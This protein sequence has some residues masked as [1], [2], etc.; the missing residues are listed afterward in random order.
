MILV[1]IFM[2]TCFANLW[3][4]PKA[5]S[6]KSYNWKLVIINKFLAQNGLNPVDI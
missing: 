3:F 2:T 5:Q 1:S 4:S 6:G